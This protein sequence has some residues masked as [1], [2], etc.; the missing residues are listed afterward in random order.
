MKHLDKLKYLEIL[1]ENL[2]GK[3]QVFEESKELNQDF[4]F[5]LVGTYANLCEEMKKIQ[6]DEYIVE[7]EELEL[8]VK[9][10]SFILEEITYLDDE[11]LLEFHAKFA[12]KDFN[13]IQSSLE[14][15]LPKSIRDSIKKKKRKKIFVTILKGFK[16]LNLN[17]IKALNEPSNL[18]S[19]LISL[20]SLALYMEAVKIA[21]VDLKY[22]NKLFYEFY[23]SLGL[24]ELKSPFIKWLDN[25][26]G[27]EERRD[28]QIYLSMLYKFEEVNIILRE[29]IKDSD[30][31]FSW[32]SEEVF[33]NK[34]ALSKTFN[35]RYSH[36]N[37]Y[38]ISGIAKYL[39]MNL[40]DIKKAHIEAQNL[41]YE[42]LLKIK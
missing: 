6:N 10:Y 22:A 37:L 23:K 7:E 20:T 26:S 32:V 8:F 5:F 40:N 25:F 15:K 41:Y 12:N 1:L 30:E 2:E 13:G 42:Y 9:L 16:G 24:L 27:I 34:Q 21:D 35:Y 39:E 19:T 36:F 18:Q 3:D 14:K 4:F 31:T 28:Y 29:R 11:D 38:E 33:S 17:L